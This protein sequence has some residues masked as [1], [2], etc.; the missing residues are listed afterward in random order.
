MKTAD[1]PRDLLEALSQNLRGG[2]RLS[3]LRGVKRDDF[4]ASA[5]AF[6]VLVVL[7][8]LVMFALAFASVGVEGQF[9]YHEL[10]RSLMFV[11]WLLVARAGVE[12]GM[13]LLLPTA[14][15]A[16]GTVVTL[17]L[18]IVGL[19]IQ[20]EV[21]PL[22]LRGYWHHLSLAG[23]VWWSVVVVTGV[24]RLVSTSLRQIVSSAI[25]G[26]LLVVAPAWWFPQ[27][28]LWIPSY[29][30][31][32]DGRSRAGLWALAEER[33][34][35]AQHEALRQ[36]LD[37][38]EPERPGI[39]DLYVLAAALYAREDVFMK[40]VQVIV[41]LFRSRF[42]AEGRALAL[43]NNP[44]TLDEHPIASLTS[45]T[46]A[47]RH[48]GQLMNTEE[49][50]LVLYVSS[51]GSDK[52][53][54]SV[55]FWPLRLEA[56]DPPA[57]KHALDESGI[58]WKVI[59]ISACYSGGFIE[60]LQDDHALIITASSASR[61][62]FGCGNE[63]DSTYLAKALFDQELRRTRSFEGAFDAA[64]SSI[65]ERERTQGFAPSE[66]QISVGAAMR[67]KL[68]EIEGRLE[69][70]AAQKIPDVAP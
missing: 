25:A 57:L 11:L 24:V 59:V 29:D 3:L 31:G 63:S 33:A 64:R 69:R 2:I 61:K 40:E 32:G 26:L 16:A 65:V 9:N 62:S 51:H 55:E 5:E 48:M 60:P 56:I 1:S 20:N 19:L 58:K 13:M 46:A 36:A 8:L 6:A 38:L 4:V 15:V 66:P 53:Q 34:F 50:V 17:V 12:P 52:H 23:I 37:A 70:S 22:P 44:R 21:L 39:A 18:G 49:D 43:I 67:K 10:P 7:D 28:Y 41:D 45:L 27:G 30:P 14:L 47:L 68:K 54:L 42:D 35:Y